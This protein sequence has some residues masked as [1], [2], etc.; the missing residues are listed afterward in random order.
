VQLHG[1]YGMTA[2]SPVERHYRAAVR[3]LPDG[4][5]LPELYAEAGPRWWG[6]DF[7]GWSGGEG[8]LP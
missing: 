8:G 6:A 7:M 4:P 1:A 5:A 3:A 2:G